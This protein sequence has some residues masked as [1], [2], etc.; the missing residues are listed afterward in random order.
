MKGITFYY[1]VLC[2]K[3]T[4]KIYNETSS[5]NELLNIWDLPFTFNSD[6]ESEPNENL[7]FFFAFLKTIY[8]RWVFQ[9]F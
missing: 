3:C 6:Y 7:F 2:L 1:Y 5:L 4:Q 9:K 8:C